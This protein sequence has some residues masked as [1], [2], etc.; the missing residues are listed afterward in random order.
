MCFSSF[1]AK[2]FVSF[3][4]H[5]NPHSTNFLD[6]LGG[7]PTLRA[8]GWSEH[9]LD[10]N[11]DLLDDSQRPSYL[12]AMAQ[13]WL[14]LTMNVLVTLLAV[15]LVVLAL[16]LR[17][18]AGNVGAGLV[19]LITLGAMLTT[20]I[21]AYTGLETSLGAISRLKAF[22]EE[23]ELEDRKHYDIVPEKGW[24]MNG[25]IRMNNVDASYDGTHKVLQGLHL[26]VGA[27]EKIAICGRTG[28]YFYPYFQFRP[29]PLADYRLSQW[30]IL[31]YCSPPPSDQPFPLQPTQHRK[32]Y[33]RSNTD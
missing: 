15:I 12:L 2:F 21:T 11:N 23:T 13:Q 26:M 16:Q 9:L 30:Q 6:T 1:F 25:S 18:N 19:T 22:E 33:T 32:F 8:F 3:A 5:I 29:R 17:S 4:D 10:R 28:R 20:I 27:G 14:T 7:L 24:P 31:N